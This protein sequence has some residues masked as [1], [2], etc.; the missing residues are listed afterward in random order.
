MIRDALRSIYWQFALSKVANDVR[1]QNLTYLSQRKLRNIERQLARI[2]RRGLPGDVVECGIALGGSA[3]VIANAMGPGRRF[4][5][6]D[7]FERIPPPS[8]RDDSKSHERYAI[9]ASGQSKGI[10][11]QRYYGYE[12]DLFERVLGSFRRFGFDPDG[13]RIHLEKGLFEKTMRF[14]PARRIA[15][16]HIDCDWHDPVSF[17]LES[18]YAALLPGGTIILDDYNDYGG[19]RSATHAFLAKRPDMRLVDATANAV[20]IKAA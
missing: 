19:C 4:L 12:D 16:A 10:A 8:E 1:Q 2:N 14:D 13:D 7:V 3:I 15:F 20:L 18:C 6:F 5:G 11:G 17:C 9:I